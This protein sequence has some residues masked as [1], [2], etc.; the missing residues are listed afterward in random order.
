[1]RLDINFLLFN[2]LILFNIELSVEVAEVDVLKSSDEVLLSFSSKLEVV[3]RPS[4]L[5]LGTGKLS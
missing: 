2:F 4:F 3:S 5:E 1:M